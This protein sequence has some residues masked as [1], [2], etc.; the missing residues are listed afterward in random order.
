MSCRTTQI[1]N[2]SVHGS[3][4]GLAEAASPLILSAALGAVLV[5]GGEMAAAFFTKIGA[6]EFKLETELLPGVSFGTVIS[7][8]A[9][10]LRVV[11]KAGGF[12]ISGSMAKLIRR[13]GLTQ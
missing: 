13:L 9:A 1:K 8:R 3:N 11:T 10:G 12:G 2:S 4:A 7:G 6:R 5:T